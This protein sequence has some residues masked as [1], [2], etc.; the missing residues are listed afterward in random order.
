M[1]KHNASR[2]S[3]SVILATW[4]RLL[5]GAEANREDL[6]ALESCRAQ[7]AAA[8]A[9]TK[10][11][12]A[13]RETLAAETRRETENLHALLGLGRELAARLASGARM[14]YGR[15]SAKLAEL[16]I[17][18]LLPRSRTKAGPGCRVKGCPLE[19]PATR[20]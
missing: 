17:K 13:R 4:E 2:G 18:V 10:A 16:G 7:L 19:A 1:S 12:Y 20:E 8:L 14:L 5:A 9:D 3:F 11:A 6:T 15:R